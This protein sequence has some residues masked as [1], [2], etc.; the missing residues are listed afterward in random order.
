MSKAVSNLRKM[1]ASTYKEWAAACRDVQQA[2]NAIVLAADADRKEKKT[3]LVFCI[4]NADRA[5]TL[6][7]RVCSTLDELEQVQDRRNGNGLT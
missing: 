4:A 3:M 7:E 1:E 2:R 6:W 5:F